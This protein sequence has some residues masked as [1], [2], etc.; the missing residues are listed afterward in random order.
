MKVLFICHPESDYGGG[1]L[2]NGLCE[3]L[4][5]KN[6]YDYP[7]KPSYHGQ[8]HNYS[9]LPHIVNG[10]T[11]PA[12][13]EVVHEYAYANVAEPHGEIRDLIQ[14]K[15]F[16]FCVVESLREVA[17][18]NFCGLRDELRHA[19]IPVVLHDGEDHQFLLKCARGSNIKAIDFALILKRELW[20]DTYPSHEFEYEGTKVVGFPFSSISASIE[21]AISTS[22]K[23]RDLDICFLAGRTWDERQRVADVLRDGNFDSYIALSPDDRGSPVVLKRWCDYIGTMRDSKIAVSVRGFGMDT[24]RFWES[25][26][27]ALM[28]TDLPPLHY[29]NPLVDGI[30]CVQF[31]GAQDCVV[32]ARALLE[33]EERRRTIYEAGRKWVLEHHTNSARVQYLIQTLRAMGRIA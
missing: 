13:W 33:D 32:K 24:V 4:G 21:H 6:V 25:P 28:L 18:S 26:L 10:N 17:V 27:C 2:F 5:A 7:I 14:A 11:G 31:A 12:A 9:L 16:D 29:V 19:G 30:H 23:E 15:E 20:K 22:E 3:V 8:V 1:F